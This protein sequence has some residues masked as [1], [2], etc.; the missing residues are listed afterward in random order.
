MEAANGLVKKTAMAE[1]MK[2]LRERIDAAREAYLRSEGLASGDALAAYQAELAMAWPT[3]SQAL[4][5][6]EQ[7]LEAERRRPMLPDTI[8]ELQALYGRVQS[9]L[10]SLVLGDQTRCV[11]LPTQS[12][13]PEHGAV[14]K[15]EGKS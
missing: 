7:S 9:K 6:A 1:S 10:M 2:E 14:S 8:P 15:E 5:T 13:E 4:T 12:P 11:T 3:I